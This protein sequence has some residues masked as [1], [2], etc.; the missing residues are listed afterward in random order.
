M[1]RT[2]SMSKILNIRENEKQIAEVAYHLSVEIFEG[3]A[4][5]LYG[6]LKK[7][8]KAEESYE[9]SIKQAT[10]IDKIKDHVN[11]VDSLNKQI[12]TMQVKVQETRSKMEKKQY[13][14]T[15]AYVEVKKFEKIIEI[16]KKEQRLLANREEQISMDEISTQQFLRRNQGEYSE[17]ER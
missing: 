6:L 4:T 9:I 3:N 12:M 2:K 7:K 11:Y 16:R 8:E 15:N 1:P 10:S 14:L 13:Q 17:Q 5:Q